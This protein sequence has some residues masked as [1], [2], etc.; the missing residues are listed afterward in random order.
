MLLFDAPH[1]HAQVPGFDDHS[2]T[3]GFDDILNGLGDLG[4]KPFLNLQPAR[5][6]LDKAGNFAEAHHFTLGHISDVH[7]AEERKQVVFAEAEHFNV[8]DDDHFIVADRE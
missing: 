5:K 3:L 6:E 2:D 7:L 1:H 8:F 4:G